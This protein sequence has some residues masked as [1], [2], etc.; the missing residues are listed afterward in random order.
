[1]NVVFD[2]LNDIVSSKDSE[3]SFWDDIVWICVSEFGWTQ[4]EIEETEIPF[5]LSLIVIR[6][7]KLKKQEAELKKSQRKR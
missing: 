3:E 7:K 2:S 4:A 1:M 6:A 5:L